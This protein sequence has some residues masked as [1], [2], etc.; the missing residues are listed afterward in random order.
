MHPL[1]MRCQTLAVLAA[2]ACLWG[3]P[4]NCFGQAAA[5]A[6]APAPSGG[7]RV[8]I[9]VARPQ[10]PA[11]AAGT[12][13]QGT[14]GAQQPV[15]R[16]LYPWKQNI[17]ATV[18]WIG[19]K[20]SENNPTPNTKSS[21]DQEWV[22][23]FGGYDDPDPAMRHQEYRPQKFVPKLNPFYIALPYNDVAGPGEYR[24]EAPRAIPWF[25]KV[26]PGPGKTMCKGRWLQIVYAGRSCFAQ[27]EDCGPW[28]TDDW[29][30]V[31]GNRPP[32]NTSNNSAAIDISPAV[33]DFLGMRSG[34]KVH[35]RFVEASQVPPG[36]W[37]RFGSSSAATSATAAASPPSA[38]LQAEQLRSE[39]LRRIRDEIYKN[40]SKWEL[41]GGY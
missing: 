14:R 30:Y 23:N 21:W 27:W 40:K 18:F 39:Q 12:P 34:E 17:T 32:K 4:A 3:V 38:E 9:P 37:L 24:P 29:E 36:P 6:A 13:Q 5:A 26:T 15:S 7:P 20:P 19:E 11:A 25:G 41:Q 31:F 8:S 22:K 35:W 1:S 10:Q 16:A 33:R 28:V 2:A